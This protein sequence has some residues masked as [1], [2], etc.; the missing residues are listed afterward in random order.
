M[1]N[2]SRLLPPRV[3]ISTKGTVLYAHPGD[4]SLRPTAS[5]I[6]ELLEEIERTCKESSDQCTLFDPQYAM[7]PDCVHGRIVAMIKALKGNDNGKE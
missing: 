1:A 7:L 2:S 5:E 6:I 3:D 4:S